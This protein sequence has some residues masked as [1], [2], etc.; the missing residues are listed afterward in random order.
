MS[1]SVARH[2]IDVTGTVANQTMT[3]NT[4]PLSI[5]QSSATGHFHGTIDEVALFNV[6]L[7]AAQV[8]H[9]AARESRNALA[10]VRPATVERPTC[11]GRWAGRSARARDQTQA[12]LSK[13][14]Y[15]T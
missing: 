11:S 1:Y 4:L 15:R 5:G 12:R 8:S 2:G 7:T 3:N 13:S 10:L 9:Y 14:R 6:A